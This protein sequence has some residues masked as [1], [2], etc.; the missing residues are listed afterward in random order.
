[1]DKKQVETTL[2]LSVCETTAGNNV[3]ISARMLTEYYLPV[4]KTCV[5]VAKVKSMMC[6]C[7]HRCC[8][9]CFPKFLF[10]FEGYGLTRQARDERDKISEE[11]AIRTVTT[12]STGSHPAPT[13]SSRMTSSVA[14]RNKPPDAEFHSFLFVPSLSWQTITSQM[15]EDD[16]DEEAHPSTA[17]LCFVA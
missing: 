4:F 3:N 16:G 8:F 10:C 5:Q 13:A 6:R 14:V 2:A 1:M 15:I 12:L 7:E 17:L 9:V 11:T